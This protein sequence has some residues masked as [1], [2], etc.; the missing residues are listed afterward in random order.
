MEPH[1]PVIEYLLSAE[2]SLHI[3]IILLGNSGA[4]KTTLANAII[5]TCSGRHWLVWYQVIKEVE[6]H[7]AVIIPTRVEHSELENIILHDF[8]GQSEYYSSNTAILQNLLQDHPAVFIN[9]VNLY[10][11][12]ALR[13]LQKWIT[14]IENVC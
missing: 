13:S 5:K 8:A 7:T 10:E 6:F 3:N 12:E 1:F 9:F 11:I 4:G 2:L 14:V